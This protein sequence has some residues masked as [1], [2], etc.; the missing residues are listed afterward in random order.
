MP[1]RLEGGIL[2]DGAGHAAFARLAGSSAMMG[3]GAPGPGPAPSAPACQRRAAMKAV[4]YRRNLP[5]AH[6]ES[7]IDLD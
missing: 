2:Q 6:D 1:E 4:G 5:V 3:C 7:L